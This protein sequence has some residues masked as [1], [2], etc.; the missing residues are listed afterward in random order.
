MP[1]P[2]QPGDPRL[3]IV[4]PVLNEADHLPRLL[5]DLEPLRVQGC[6]IIVV[7]GGSRD[8]TLAVAAAGADRVLHGPRGRA[9]QMNTGAARAR[10][11][12]LWFLHAD[13]RVPGSVAAALP[14]PDQG[15]W[16]WG[17]CGVRLSGD[18]RAFRLI[19][20]LMN[21]R[22]CLT[23]IATG[24]QGIFVRRAAFERVGG[25]PE[26]PL[27]EDIALSRQLKQSFGRPC[28]LRA[29]LIT[30]SR[31]WETGGIGRTVLLMWS[32]RLAY[33]AGADPAALARR[34]RSAQALPGG[35]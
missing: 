29:H 13:T 23:G 9:L 33:W 7:D 22:S 17:R 18:R 5:G 12:V 3:S 26:I 34:Y 31:R 15:A 8:A 21:L 4:I 14:D 16:S 24:D 6:E 1:E 11:A 10:G 30:S 28:C 19:G 32:L 25:F 20:A 2:A 27:M 35:S